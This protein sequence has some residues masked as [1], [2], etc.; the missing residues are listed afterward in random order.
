MI[1][2][3]GY[4]YQSDK[5]SPT[6]NGWTYFYVKTDDVSKAKTK[7]KSYWK[8]FL[9]E[10]GWTKKAKIVHLEE[11]RNEK[12]Y[13]PGFIVVSSDELPA[14]RTRKSTSGSRRSKSTPSRSPTRSSSRPPTRSQARTKKKTT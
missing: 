12:T 14:A 6:E 5:N 4:T 10:N 3:I 9:T 1:I 2:E 11:I 8:K 7:A 13:I